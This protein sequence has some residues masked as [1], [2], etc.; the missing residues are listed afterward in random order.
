MWNRVCSAW[1]V[2]ICAAVG[3][4]RAPIDQAEVQA[5][6]PLTANATLSA[7]EAE[8]LADLN[9]ALWAAESVDPSAESYREALI[10]RSEL[11]LLY[12]A[13]FGASRKQQRLY[14]RRAYDFAQQ[15]FL[16]RTEV[17]PER[18]GEEDFDPL[19]LRTT[20]TFYLFRDTYGLLERIRRRSELTA[21]RETLDTMMRLNRNWEDGV[22]QFSL[23]IYYLSLPGV[24][25]GDL[26]V[27]ETLINEGVTA[28]PKRLVALWGRGKYLAVKLKDTDMFQRDL[29]RVAE[30]PADQ[31]EGPALWNRYFQIDAR[32][33]LE[34]ANHAAAAK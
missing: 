21:A 8:L 12:G 32:R 7:A 1:L 24:F 20:A 14:Y 11:M 26:T 29:Q 5:S 18:I 13:A 30:F 31:L 33:L 19:L 15:A 22:L 4:C 34:A 6:P 17:D 25:G 9:T 28:G 2:L 27:A 10:Q 16:I 3:G 23:G